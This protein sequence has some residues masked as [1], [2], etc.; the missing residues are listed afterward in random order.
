[1]ITQ[2]RI[3][4]RAALPL[5]LAPALPSTSYGFAEIAR[6]ALLLETTAS[7]TY[8]S[9]FLGT[10][11]N[12][13]DTIYT[14]HPSLRYTRNAGRGTIAASAGMAFNRYETNTDLDSDDI[15]ANLS[16]K[17]PTVEGARLDGNFT[18][19]YTEATVVDIVVNDRVATE[20]FNLGLSL[21]YRTGDRTSLK[22]AFN[23]SNSVRD[24][25]SDQETLSNDLTFTYEG[26]LRGTSLSLSHSMEL[27]T[28][29]GDNY[30]GVG[31]DQQS[32]GLN[33]G[34]SR[35]IY[36]SIIGSLNYGYSILTRS[37]AEVAPG[38]DNKT[39][40]SY[41]S[42]SVSGPF[43]PRRYF[44][45]LTSSASLSYSQPAF[46]G[47]NDSSG[48]FLSGDLSVSWAAR[49][50]TSFT[51]AATRSM[52]LSVVDTATENTRLGIG[53]NQTIG[54]STSLAG[55]L[56]YNWI[57]HRGSDRNDSIFDAG[58][59]LSHTFNKYLR[60]STGYT[61][62]RNDS[63]STGFQP[64]RFAP[65]DYERHTATGSLTVTF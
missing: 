18:A 60:A 39:T 52:Q 32:H 53:F 43:L 40:S 37:D 62:A 13:P 15:R 26:F 49:E 54:R 61:F 14:L 29:S 45:K 2:H 65:R 4:L 24:A 16:I 44:P 5:L 1:V 31:L 51:I 12:A 25:Y 11:D 33:L 58:L 42:A 20:S 35:P 36:D 34:L 9:Y 64:G 47:V 55:N 6:G 21:N 63:S 28:T 59:T 41:I 19:S 56:G 30:T 10:A 3:A 50:R 8:D 17:L 57:T 22:E 48:K 7:A 23:Y 38:T 46:A 27:T